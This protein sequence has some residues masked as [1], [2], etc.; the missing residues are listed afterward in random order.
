MFNHPKYA[1]IIIV[2]VKY[3]GT[4]RWFSSDKEIWFLDLPKLVVSYL[5][6]GFD[7]RNR[8]DFSDRFHIEVVNENTVENFL[9]QI[10][11]LEV[12]TEDLKA[13]LEQQTYAQ[14]SDMF[15]SLYLDFDGKKLVSCYPEPASYEEYVPDGWL[16]R[17]EEFLEDV[18]EG[19]RYWVIRGENFFYKESNGG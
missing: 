16:G 7:I 18:P 19:C 4:Y 17:Y 8:D 9:N 3:K 15:P 6:A 5:R 2:L 12:T 1:E 11:D 10:N 14:I 13:I